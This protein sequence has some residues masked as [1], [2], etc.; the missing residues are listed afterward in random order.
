MKTH[1]A[2]LEETFLRGQRQKLFAHLQAIGVSPH[3]PD[4][5]SAIKNAENAAAGKMTDVILVD[6]LFLY[7]CGKAGV[8]PTRRQASK[9]RKGEGAAWEQVNKLSADELAKFTS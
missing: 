2:I 9:F 4:V 6:S 1:Q 3:R 5:T 8:E 7:C